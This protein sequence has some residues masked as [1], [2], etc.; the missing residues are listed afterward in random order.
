MWARG[1]VSTTECPK[2]LMTPQ[3]IEW[4]ERFSAWKI[5]GQPTDKELSAKDLD[6]LWVLER[7]WKEVMRGAES[8]R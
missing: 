5:T 2:S 7:Q 1:K 8:P 4:V 6:A 3:S